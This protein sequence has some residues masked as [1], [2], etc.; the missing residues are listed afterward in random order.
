MSELEGLMDG[1]A[2]EHETEHR[3]DLD[4]YSTDWSEERLNEEIAKRKPYLESCSYWNEVLDYMENVREVRDISMF[5][6][7]LYNTDTKVY[8]RAEF[9]DVP[10]LILHLAKNEIYAR[11]GYIFQN[12]DLK[13]Y[14]MGQVW[15]MPRC[16][17]AAFD[18]G[19]FNETERQ[20]LELLRVL[21][22]YKE[23]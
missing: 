6:D 20:N 4:Q 1:Q 12:A 22:T 21:D 7:P 16:T 11:H 17:A 5:T 2:Q 23:L 14:F 9:E 15:Y 8:V 18:D 10:P 3:S 13:A 19:V